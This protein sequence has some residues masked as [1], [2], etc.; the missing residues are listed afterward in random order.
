MRSI[1]LAASAVLALSGAAYAQAPAKSTVTTTAPA[2]GKPGMTRT[3]KTTA[4]ANK[5]RTAASIACSGQADSKTLHGKDRK[6]FMSSCKKAA[7]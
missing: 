2:P 7:K 5:P 1:I 4:T 3:T 6:K